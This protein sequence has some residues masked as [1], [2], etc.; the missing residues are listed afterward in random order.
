VLSDL[1]YRLRSLF[2]RRQAEDD[3]RDELQY[4]LERETEKYIR[5]GVAPQE[6]E[7]KARLAFGGPEQVR[8]Q[9]REGRGTRFVENSLQDLRYGA[10]SLARNRGFAVVFILTLALGIGSCTAI[11]SLITAVMFP[12]LPY[13][14]P[15]RLVYLTTPNRSLT[16]VPPDV[17]TPDNA[18]FA[19][20][21]RQSHSFSGMTQFEQAKFKL[22]LK[23][24]EMPIGGAQVDG[25]FFSTLQ[26]SP[27]L[28]RAIDA[29][30]DQP[31]H[32][33]VLLISHSLWLQL[34]AG[35]RNALG[36]AL[37]LNGRSY[38]I[39]G[40]MPADFGFPHKTDLDYGD[41]HIDTTDAWIPLALTAKERA[42]RGLSSNCHALLR[43]KPGVA[44]NQAQAELNSIMSRLDPLHDPTTFVAGWYAHLKPFRQTLEGSARPLMSLLLGAV[45]F[46]L[47]IACG[48]A[49]NLL[50]ARSA[51]RTHELGVR[52]AL[53]A[54]RSRLIHQ[55]LTESLLL[56]IG[57]G[58]AGIGLAW[59][60]LRLL[61]RLDPGDIPRLNEAS[62]NSRVLVFTILITLL[63]SIMAGILPALWSSRIN[64]VEF[65]K[66]G[67]NRGAIGGRNRLRSS[68]IVGEVATVV[69]LLAGAGLLLRSYIKLQAVPTGFSST[70]LSMKIDLPAKYSQSVQRHEFFHT[71]LEQIRSTPGVQA[72][73]AVNNLPFGDTQGVENFWVEGYP[74]QKGQMVDGGSV[75]PGYFA[76]MN[77]PVIEGQ[78]F[79][80]DDSPVHSR[81]AIIN[82]A[83]AKKYFAGRDPI[84]KWVRTD[85]PNSSTNPYADGKTIV[86]V[87]A[88][89]R[90]WKLE[91]AA[92]PQLF[93]PLADPDDAYIAVR[94][95]LP[96][97][98]VASA[99]S[100]ILRRIEPSLSFTKM[101]TMGEL[102]SVATARR[103]FQTT[104]LTVFSAMAMLLALVGFYG[105]LVY[106]VRQRSAE[107]GVRIAL[108][109][110]RA[111]VMQLVLRQGLQLVTA[112]MS[113]GLIGALTLTRVLASSLYDV[114]ALDPV[115][116]AA[117]PLLLLVATVA[118]CL[119]PARRAAN[120][121]PMSAIRYE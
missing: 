116:F 21:K 78:P 44:V 5:T 114:S 45:S 32:D 102:V 49:A 54:G 4:H 89:V 120:I 8:Q 119:I 96:L 118:A 103:R 23:G 22:R 73:G 38:R 58:L 90:E 109:A 94:S 11:F 86:G 97:K 10:R 100:S 33:G 48:N 68:L 59:L 95:T 6:A 19:D 13:G 25:D 108:G 75:T 65:L 37:Q 93:L 15:G 3:L 42:D 61:L 115:T 85:Q 99:S 112:G 105:L 35:S 101:H 39:I 63:A 26:S 84:G 67:G 104:L 82:Q 1:I 92:P 70:T 24:T 30:D 88:D 66:S 14:D 74:N 43:M 12:P 50:L 106:L 56:G 2:R 91:E 60:F 55:M 17:V 83:F 81:V 79:G 111:N 31:G 53:G 34:F 28:G 113:L 46:V 69:V 40:I 71:L 117:V 18:D 72:A 52:T 47:L 110:S 20:L 41:D 76:A 62:L 87:V 9:C 29:D 98:D 27:V 107:M 121:D 77:I 7:R 16:Q 80:D 64:L 57:G 51:S 36:S